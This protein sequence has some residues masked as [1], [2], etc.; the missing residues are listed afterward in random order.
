M[1]ITRLLCSLCKTESEKAHLGGLFVSKAIKHDSS[2]VKKALYVSLLIWM[3]KF[4]QFR[5][6]IVSPP[7][8]YVWDSKK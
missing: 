7:T 5:S 1:P 8:K 4:V 6:W 2:F 3:P